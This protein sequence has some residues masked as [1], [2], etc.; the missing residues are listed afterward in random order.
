MRTV[1]T[2]SRAVVLLCSGAFVLASTGAPEH[3]STRAPAGVQQPA[4]AASGL[5]AGRVLDVTSGQP[6]AGV[7]VSMSGAATVQT[8]SQGRFA[9]PSLA[10]GRYTLRVRHDGHAPVRGA[11]VNLR[12]DQL[13]TDVELQ[14]G[15]HSIIAGTVRDDGGDPV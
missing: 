9:F 3:E 10:S 8:D 11:A 13:V 4:A 14:V 2:C 12:A 5:I 1:L 15:R 6:V 7:T